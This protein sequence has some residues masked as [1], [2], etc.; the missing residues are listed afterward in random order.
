MVATAT[1]P[2]IAL[3]LSET[4]GHGILTRPRACISPADFV[5]HVNSPFRDVMIIQGHSVRP[6]SDMPAI[7]DFQKSTSDKIDR[8]E[9]F[10]EDH[11]L[12]V[13][14]MFSQKRDKLRA[15]SWHSD[16]DHD[17][18]TTVHSLPFSTFRNHCWCTSVDLRM[19][20]MNAWLFIGLWTLPVVLAVPIL[21]GERNP[22]LCNA[23]CTDGPRGK[24]PCLPI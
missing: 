21:T 4:N 1:Y 23:A 11:S 15:D 18:F 16:C 5:V 20:H 2:T 3:S 6:Q 8:R 12:P 19:S 14:L 9:I 24:T 7:P 13:A 17:I 10:D 22:S